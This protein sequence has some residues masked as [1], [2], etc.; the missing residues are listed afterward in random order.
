[1][2]YPLLNE[3]S[4]RSFGQDYFKRAPNVIFE[5]Y[6]SFNETNVEHQQKNSQKTVKVEE[7]K[8][9]NAFYSFLSRTKSINK[10][11]VT[12]E[13]SEITIKEEVKCYLKII[14]D[15]AHLPDEERP[16]AFT[17]WKGNREEM[18][19]LRDLAI[20]LM[21]IPSTSAFIERFFSIC[22]VVNDKRRCNMRNDTFI[23]RC[24]LKS[25]YL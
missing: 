3:W 9:N 4:T 8:G 5:V 12:T 18:P 23:A 17:F 14:S 6:Q 15:N 21:T 11:N 25:N 1:L 24:L 7:K 13:I 16:S 10:T 22:G 2:N 19:N 20:K